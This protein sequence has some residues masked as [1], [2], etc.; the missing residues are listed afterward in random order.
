MGKMQAH[1]PVC[2]HCLQS[3]R[4]KFSDY[5]D[6]CSGCICYSLPFLSVDANIKPLWVTLWWPPFIDYSKFS[7]LIFLTIQ[8]AD[9]EIGRKEELKRT[10]E[11]LSQQFAHLEMVKVLPNDLEQREF[12]AN[13]ALDVRSASMTYLAFM[14][15][16]DATP[17]GTPGTTL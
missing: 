3:I 15:C 16:H 12:V 5:C 10:L 4:Q 13:R 11:Y 14:I 8:I 9:K 7:C 17:L 6:E 1:N 2:I